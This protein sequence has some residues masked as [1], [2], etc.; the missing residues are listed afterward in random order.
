[1]NMEHGLLNDLVSMVERGGD[2]ERTACLFAAAERL[3]PGLVN[4]FSPIER[5]WREQDIQTVR[6]ALGEEGYRTHFDLGRG[7]PLEQAVE[8]ALK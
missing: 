4:H 3:F 1:M 5:G 7:M 6:A 8:Y 2:M